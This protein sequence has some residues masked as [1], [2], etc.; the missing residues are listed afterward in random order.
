MRIEIVAKNYQV[1]D[2]LQEVIEKKVARLDKYFEEDAT[3]RIYLKVEKRD[4]KMELSINY[5]GTFI[6]AEAKGDNFYDTIDVLLPKIERQIY[7]Y[8]SKFEAKLRA[9]ALKQEMIY[10]EKIEN[11]FKL[12]K[13]KKFELTPM[14]LDEAIEEFELTGHSFF[15]YFDKDSEKTKVLYLRDDGNIGLIDPVIR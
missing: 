11:D 7:K 5:K 1:K 14:S 6:R 4:S 2:Q 15:V 3:C 8:R 10:E 13:T 9:G 12:V